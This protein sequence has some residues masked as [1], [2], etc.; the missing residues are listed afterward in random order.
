MKAEKSLSDGIPLVK[1]KESKAEVDT[2]LYKLY[3]AIMDTTI[4][5]ERNF[6]II[7][8]NF[9]SVDLPAKSAYCFYFR[10]IQVNK[11]ASLSEE[12]SINSFKMWK[13]NKEKCINLLE[14]VS[15]L[16]IDIRSD[17]F[18]ALVQ[19]MC[20]DLNANDYNLPLFKKDFPSLKDSVSLG[21]A[22]S[23]FDNWVE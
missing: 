1:N 17:I 22:K 14:Y 8:K 19:A 3:K 6:D 18:K 12:I 13:E 16:P 15:G 21:S 4:S 7:Q 5:D 23:C 9:F 2:S 11:D 10:F 20:L